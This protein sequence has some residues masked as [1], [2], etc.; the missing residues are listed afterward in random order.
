MRIV[1]QPGHMTK[2]IP[3]GKSSPRVRD[4]INRA[5][6]HN[7]GYAGGKILR[8]RMARLASRKLGHEQIIADIRKRTKSVPESAFKLPGAMK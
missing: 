6:A 1:T 5:R 7:A 8:K 3:E 2:H 4:N